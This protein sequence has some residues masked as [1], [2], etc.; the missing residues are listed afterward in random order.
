MATFVGPNGSHEVALEQPQVWCLQLIHHF[1]EEVMGRPE[2]FPDAEEALDVGNHLVMS[3]LSMRLYG[4][5]KGDSGSAR[6][7]SYAREY[8]RKSLE[9]AQ[10][11]GL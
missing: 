4:P 5:Q 9:T 2:Q 6:V 3:L 8:L 7:A 1:L 10:L 11:M